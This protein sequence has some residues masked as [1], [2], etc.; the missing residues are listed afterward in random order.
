MPGYFALGMHVLEILRSRGLSQES[1]SIPEY[2]GLF[3]P[4]FSCRCASLGLALSLET[5]GRGAN[6]TGGVKGTRFG[7]GD[8]VFLWRGAD[9]DRPVVEIMR[10]SETLRPPTQGSHAVFPIAKEMP[11]RQGFAR[12]LHMYEARKCVRDFPNVGSP[13]RWPMNPFPFTMPGRAVAVW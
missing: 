8:T 9:L 2:A 10:V 4:V 13:T 7:V 6:P 3:T 1:S 12:F 5:V 11:T